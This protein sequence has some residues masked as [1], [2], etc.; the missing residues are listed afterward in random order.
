MKFYIAS[1][2]SLI[3]QVEFYCDALEREGHEVTV[4]WWK[5]LS[6][7]KQF[8]ILSP[9]AFYA[10]PECK[11]AFE[12]DLQGIKEADA[13]LF[14]AASEPRSYNGANVEVGIAFGLG[15]PVFSLGTL[16][17]SAM[18]WGITRC[19]TIHEVLTEASRLS[20]QLRKG[21]P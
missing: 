12:R 14:V 20:Q 17:N 6:L 13:L 18:Y 15:K 10:E 21:K 16:T 5:R 8:Q 2:F 1:S 4:K 9:D 7:K 11:Y 19:V 3:K